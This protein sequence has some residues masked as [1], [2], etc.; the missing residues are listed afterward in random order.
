MT[1]NF[2]VIAQREIYRTDK[3]DP[4][5][6]TTTF[7]FLDDRVSFNYN[8]NIQ[9]I[10]NDVIFDSFLSLLDYYAYMIM[11]YDEDSYFPRGGN[12]YFQKAL[13]I[14]NKPKSDNRGWT[15]T[16]G[17]TRPSR[18]QLAQE[19]LNPRFDDYRRGFFEYHWMGL[20]SLGINRTN[21]YNNIL[22][23][24]TRISNVKK[25]EV[26]SFNPDI[27]FDAKAEE[28]ATTFLDYGDNSIFNKLI[29][30]DPAHQRIYEQIRDSR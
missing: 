25:R 17:G 16:G 18:L 23:A 20:D 3:R 8:Q 29:E 12:V 26:K 14:C 11:G 13:Q 4:I 15:E 1:H 6:Y 24:L 27:F 10:K 5:V 21:A 2:F 19:L 22:R 28:I 7:K 9:F 30:L